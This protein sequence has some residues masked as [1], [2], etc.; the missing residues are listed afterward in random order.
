MEGN[1]RK[2]ILGPKSQDMHP[3]GVTKDGEDTAKN[4]GTWSKLTAVL[5]PMFL[6]RYRGS[7]RETG[8]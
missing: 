5:G 4:G 3:G 2:T 7:R 6:A 8:E 1:K